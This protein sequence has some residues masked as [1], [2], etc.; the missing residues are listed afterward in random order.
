MQAYG[1]PM[2]IEFE[3]HHP[4]PVADACFSFQ[5]INAN[6]Q[7]VVHLWL[8]SADRV[9]ANQ[10]GITILR[11]EIPFVHMNV[12]SYNLRT[13][14]SG[15]PGSPF[16]EQTEPPLTFE[17]VRMDRPTLFGWRNE[18][19]TYFEQGEWQIVTDPKT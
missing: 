8:Y 13:F 2:R 15:P 12:G 10:P 14:F 19:C 16:F 3:L 7:P 18:A 4:Q 1:K 17:V 6:A 5:T 9:F 11:C